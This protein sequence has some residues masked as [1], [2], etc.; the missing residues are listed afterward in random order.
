MLY[1]SYYEDYK[2]VK[3]KNSPKYVS[4]ASGKEEILP[5]TGDQQCKVT[6]SGANDK[7]RV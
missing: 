5:F 2:S 6:E 1:Q 3:Q 7:S 4:R